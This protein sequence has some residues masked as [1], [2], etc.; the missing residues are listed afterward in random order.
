MRPSAHWSTEMRTPRTAASARASVAR[1]AA[2][3]APPLCACNTDKLL[4]RGSSIAACASVAAVFRWRRA[5]WGGGSKLGRWRG[6]AIWAVKRLRRCAGVRRH[7]LHTRRLRRN[8]ARHL[9]SV[10]RAACC[11]VLAHLESLKR[12]DEASALSVAASRRRR[13]HPWSPSQRLH[14]DGSVRVIRQEALRQRQMRTTTRVCAALLSALAKRR[15]ALLTA[16][17][18][19]LISSPPARAELGTAACSMHAVMRFSRARR[20]PPWP[21]SNALRARTL[22]DLLLRHAPPVQKVRAQSEAREREHCDA[23]AHTATRRAHHRLFDG[24]KPKAP[25]KSARPG[26]TRMP[27]S[28]R[29]ARAPSRSARDARTCKSAVAARRIVRPLELVHACLRLRAC[30]SVRREGVQARRLGRRRRAAAS[31]EWC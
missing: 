19:L 30:K 8:A 10:V 18:V 23:A 29:A 14:G 2:A 31:R 7:K 21:R 20:C 11:S 1:A 4:A 22:L 26:A 28:A 25:A 13:P 24:R 12:C 3:H 17:A 16:S 9:R 27:Q 15:H 6:R 5:A